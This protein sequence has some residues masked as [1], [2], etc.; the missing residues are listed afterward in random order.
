MKIYICNAQISKLHNLNKQVLLCIFYGHV[1]VTND[2][3]QN[4]ITHNTRKLCDS[5][6]ISNFVLCNKKK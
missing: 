3:E 5:K 1:F 4:S 6:R 2:F